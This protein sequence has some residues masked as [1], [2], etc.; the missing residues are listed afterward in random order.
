M[1]IDG[2]FKSVLPS[3]EDT[4]TYS[5]SISGSL[6]GRVPSLVQNQLVKDGVD[7]VPG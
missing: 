6:V 1:F 5:V 2:F 3:E 4:E 7:A